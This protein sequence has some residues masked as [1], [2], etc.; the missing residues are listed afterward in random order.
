MSTCSRG[1]AAS[2]LPQDGRD[3]GQLRLW[4]ST[5]TA[6]PSCAVNAPHR[7]D[8]VWIVANAIGRGCGEAGKSGGV[9]E[10]SGRTSHAVMST[11]KSGSD[12]A[13]AEE[14]AVRPGLCEEDAGG[15][16]GRRS[17]DC[18]RR[19][20]QPRLGDALDGLPAWMVGWGDDWEEGV[21]R[22][23]K[24]VEERVNKLK[25]L[26][27]AIV[28]QVAYQILKAIADIEGGKR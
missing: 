21:P 10:V 2:P 15:E 25:A 19:S 23:A 24:G 9:A 1:S 4:K 5:P 16:W 26:G 22:V 12:V 20:T 13:H 17:G 28:P 11:E 18:R 27:N 7:R 14:G 6:R 8:R 3:S